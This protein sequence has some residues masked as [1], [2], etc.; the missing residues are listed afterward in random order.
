[1]TILTEKQRKYLT[2]RFIKGM[3]ARDIAKEE[4]ITHQAVEKHISAAIK[5]FEKTFGDFFGK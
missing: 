4:G 1:M 2:L 3:S 5:K